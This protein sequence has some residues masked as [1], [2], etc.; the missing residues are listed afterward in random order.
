MGFPGIVLVLPGSGLEGPHAAVVGAR[1]KLER[2][3]F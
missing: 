3:W 1:L 2:N